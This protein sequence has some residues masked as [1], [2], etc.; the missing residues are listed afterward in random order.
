MVW[1]FFRPRQD[2][3]LLVVIFLAPLLTLPLMMGRIDPNMDVT[4]VAAIALLHVALT[5]AYIQIYPASQADSPTLKI[6]MIVE[7]GMPAGL[8]EAEI[9]KSFRQED[10]FDAKVRDLMESGLVTQSGGQ[11]EITRRGKNFV[12]PFLFIRRWVG[13]PFGEG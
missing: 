10:L 2:A 9:R 1:R 6:M 3:L 5:C 11:I 12:T 13:L 7:K 4:D 8:T